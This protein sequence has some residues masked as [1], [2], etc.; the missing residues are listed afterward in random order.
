MFNRYRFAIFASLAILTFSGGAQAWNGPGHETV[1][2]IACYELTDGQKMA[3]YELLKN[4]PHTNIA[5]KNGEGEQL[6]SR[7]KIGTLESLV[8]RGRKL[9][10]HSSSGE[11]P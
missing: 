4:H 5:S 2:M 11:T 3:L 1:A 10:P 7:W 9:L 8:D 6:K